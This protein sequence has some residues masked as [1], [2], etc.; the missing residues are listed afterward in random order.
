[1]DLKKNRKCN[2][3]RHEDGFVDV[4]VKIIG[5]EI[6]SPSKRNE[7]P[8]CYEDLRNEEVLKVRGFENEISGN[9]QAK[10]QVE[11]EILQKVKI[12]YVSRGRASDYENL[13]KETV[14]EIGNGS[15]S[16]GHSQRECQVSLRAITEY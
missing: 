13:E 1:M 2:K 5:G 3:P 4:R 8:G 9:I 10:Q 11:T 16:R 12:D 14:N 6:K 15:L 7:Y